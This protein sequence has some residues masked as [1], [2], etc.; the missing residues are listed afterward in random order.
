MP[1]SASV[2]AAGWSGTGGGAE[3]GRGHSAGSSRALAAVETGLVFNPV[4][5]LLSAAA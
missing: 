5:S 2:G 3:T 1:A 4:S